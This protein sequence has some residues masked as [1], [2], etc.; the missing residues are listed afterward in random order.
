MPVR[1]AHTFAALIT[2]AVLLSTGATP[3]A[4]ATT[5]IIYTFQGGRDGGQPWASLLVDERTG[6]LYGTTEVGGNSQCENYFQ[7]GCGVIFSLT[8]SNTGWREQV[9]YRFQGGN[10][11]GHPRSPLTPRAD[12]YFYGTTTTGGGG[13]QGGLGT[14]FRIMP[15]S[16]KEQVIFSFT[17]DSSGAYPQGAIAFDKSGDLFGLT[18]NGGAG[19]GV[20]YELIP[21]DANQWTEAVLTASL[22]GPYA[23]LV[24]NQQ[25]HLFGADAVGGRYNEGSVFELAHQEGQWHFRDIYSFLIPCGMSCGGAQSSDLTLTRNGDLI[26]FAPDAGIQ[27]CN[28]YSCG[29]VYEMSNRDGIWT[30]KTLY[31]FK[32]FADGWGPDYGAPA[33]DASGNIFGATEGGGRY[34]LGTVFELSRKNG[35]WEK[36]TLYDFRGGALGSGPFAGLLI[37][38]NG[39]LFGTTYGGGKVGGKTCKKQG[40]GVVF[41]VTP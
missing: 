12:G 1:A 13:I 32:N 21:S 29:L 18:T 41:E 3:A 25:G 28:G 40:C 20:A 22:G 19:S 36:T 2:A 10:D 31:A 4:A 34:G 14:A 26:G 27:A 17:S 9:L 5:K 7:F 11:G 6:T 39:D 35:V 33:I 8:P 15:G 23:G 16:W 38:P 37:G 24:I 30:E